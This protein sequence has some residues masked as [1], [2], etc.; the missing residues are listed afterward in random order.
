MEDGIRTS[1]RYLIFILLTV[2]LLFKCE[3]E[4]SLDRNSEYEAVKLAIN[5]VIGWAVE[6]D[7]D[8]F[9]ST[10]ADDSNFISVTPNER[11]KFGVADVKND[12]AFW[13]SP[14]FKAVSHEIHDLRINFS[15]DGK[16][17]WFYCV[18]DDFNTWKGQ[19]A[20]WEKVRWT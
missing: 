7:F 8:L 4:R 10:I 20:N 14:N 3:K 11:V 2:S 9:F 17:A 16:V 13:A 1:R 19:P 15:R 18:L 6:K 5:N 12:T